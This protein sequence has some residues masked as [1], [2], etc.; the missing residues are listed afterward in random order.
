[1]INN[2]L[3]IALKTLK[4]EKADNISILENKLSLLLNDSKF[5]EIYNK[6][7][8]F[9]I[10]YGK[11]K[12]IGSEK[13]KA[14]AKEKLEKVITDIKN[15]LTKNGYAADYLTVKHS[16]NICKDEFYINNKPCSC[17]TKKYNE[18]LLHSSNIDLDG[19]K[20]FSEYDYSLFSD[21]EKI[22]VEKI[23]VTLAKIIEKLD[24]TTTKTVT[25]SGK[26]GSGKTYLAKS[27][28]KSII[29]SGRTA[30]FISSY[31]MNRVFL[32]NHLDYKNMSKLNELFDSEILIIDDLGSEKITKNVT[33]EYLYQLISERTLK[34]KFTIFTTN[35]STDSLINTYGER[36]FSRLLHKKH[37]LFIK[38]D[39]KDLRI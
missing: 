14:A 25:F 34:G 21:S 13:E 28:L 37:S 35:L 12:A 4:K 2:N 7:R 32:E 27:F 16:C 10:E 39:H 9:T 38:F 26:T 5:S 19:V 8:A 3:N 29:D 20:K 18:I 1:M 30:K 31:E 22:N 36:I 33:A 11:A 23:I 6:K 24:I 17:L 15:Y